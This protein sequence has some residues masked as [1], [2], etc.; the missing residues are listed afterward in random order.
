MYPHTFRGEDSLKRYNRWMSY[1]TLFFDL[2]DTLYP[3]AC[4]L[5]SAIRERMGLYMVERLGLPADRVPEMRRCYFEHYGTTL[6]G[7]QIH[8]QVD[9]DE[10]LAYVHDLPL[11][12]YLHPSPE[13]YELIRSLPQRR[14][15]FTNAD[16]NHARR[17]LQQLALQDLFPAII[18]IRAMEWVC[19]PD[20]AAYRAALKLAGDPDPQACLMI[21]DS[22][23]NLA[24]ARRLGLT[25]V[26]VS[27]KDGQHPAATHIISSLLELRSNVPDLWNGKVSNG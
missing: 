14:Y 27:A 21:D 2:D 15:I 19:K 10:Y 7:L 1:S 5:W 18:D 24:P 12:D 23:A 16:A 20:E 4:G 25:T 26:L 3:N 13:V 8:H 17:V 11:D 22:P 6:R 9:A